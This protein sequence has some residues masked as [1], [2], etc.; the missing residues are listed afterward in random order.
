MKRVPLGSLRGEARRFFAAFQPSETPVVVEDD[1]R[2]IAAV[3]SPWQ[4]DSWED[5]QRKLDKLLK[6][7]RAANRRV[8]GEEIE[9]AIEAAIR[10]VRQEAA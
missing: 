1:G 5:N 6:R 4:L 7:L 9:A 10:D 8:R 3:V 2:P